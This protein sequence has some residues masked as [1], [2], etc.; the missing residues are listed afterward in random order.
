MRYYS[1][2]AIQILGDNNIIRM[3]CSRMPECNAGN[4][5]VIVFLLMLAKCAIVRRVYTRKEHARAGS[6]NYLC[7]STPNMILYVTKRFIEHSFLVQPNKGELFTQIT[8]FLKN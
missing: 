1:G 6:L 4:N 3:L 7:C 8:H 5:E 2:R